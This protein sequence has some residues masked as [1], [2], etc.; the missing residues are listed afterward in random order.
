MD[1]KWKVAFNKSNDQYLSG[2]YKYIVYQQ[3]KW[4]GE[5]GKKLRNVIKKDELMNHCE[6]YILSNRDSMVRCK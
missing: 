6:N 1:Y 2:D 5:R 3:H 4:E